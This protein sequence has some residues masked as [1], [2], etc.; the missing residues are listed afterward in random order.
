MLPRH[1][2]LS[3]D[4]RHPVWAFGGVAGIWYLNN[5]EIPPSCR[6]W[7]LSKLHN[8]QIGAKRNRTRTQVICFTAADELEAHE[9]DSN[10]EDARQRRA[11]RWNDDPWCCVCSR[12]R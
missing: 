3:S 11:G 12:V 10:L 2:Q 5:R 8:G 4:P 6:I 7:V 9:I 1:S